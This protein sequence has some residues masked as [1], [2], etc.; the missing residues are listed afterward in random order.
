MTC[1]Q[2]SRTTSAVRSASRS[3]SRSTTPG[4]GEHRLAGRIRARQPDGLGD[5]PRDAVAAGQPC[6]EGRT[7]PRRGK[8]ASRLSANSVARRVLPHPPAPTSVTNRCSSRSSPIPARSCGRDRRSSTAPGAGWSVWCPPW[9]RRCVGDWRAGGQLERVVLSEDRRLH[10]GAARARAPIR[11]PRPGPGGR[12]DTPAARRPGVRTGTRPASAAHEGARGM[13]TARIAASRS[14]T[15]RR[16]DRPPAERRTAPPP[17]PLAAPP[18]E[19]PPPSPS[20]RRRTP[21][22][23]H[24]ARGRA[25]R[26]STRAPSSSAPR[27]TRHGRRAP[28]VR[29]ATRRRR[30]AGSIRT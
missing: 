7:K 24:P 5:G 19:P 20:A 13:A 25:R 8:S 15:G 27:P 3:C 30:S 21:R 1:S 23:R 16:D 14:G 28:G 9:E 26:R 18:A 6:P 2:L 29:S 10:S 22:A 17:S 12:H 11:A 4:D